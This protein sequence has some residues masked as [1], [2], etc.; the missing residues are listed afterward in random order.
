[1]TD[2]L[3]QAQKL[4][5]KYPTP[6]LLIDLDSIKQ[7]YQ[8]LKKSFSGIK[9]HYAMKANPLPKIL[10]VLSKEKAG[11]E[12][13]SITELQQLL[14]IG[15]SPD[16]IIS[17]NPVKT[18][19]FIQFAHQKGV[20]TFAFDSFDEVDKMAKLAPKSNVVL[21]I[22]VD[23]TG[24]DWP[25]TRKFGVP[26]SDALQ[27][28]QY[29]KKKS[30][31]PYG[32]TFHVGSQCLNISNWAN[33]LYT[34]ERIWH[35]AQKVGINL[36]MLSLGGGLPVQ[37]TKKIPRLEEVQQAVQ[38]VIENNF[39]DQDL[40][41]SIEPGRAIVGDSAILVASVIG[42]AK[43]GS[44]NWIYLDVG[45]FNGLM[46]TIEKFRYEIK[47]DRVPV[48]GVYTLA[49]PSCD[50]VDIVM[51]DVPLPQLTIG[52]KVYFLNT[53]AYTL[54]YASHFNGFAPPEVHFL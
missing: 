6:F 33:A 35:Q 44:E 30:L 39:S 54:P 38:R 45:V 23:N 15:V 52:D 40:H 28:L 37:H 5:K 20:N 18:P 43:R 48:Q 14:D 3:P 21:R 7:K 29:A 42:R 24:S 53:G 16:R 31:V 41:L 1:M 47:T 27:Y 9:V 32:L 17:F 46:E 50:S 22:T 2:L 4:A 51:E 11:F 12:V 10:K 25:L 49:G 13:T 26:A 36:K 34:C 8:L 19:E